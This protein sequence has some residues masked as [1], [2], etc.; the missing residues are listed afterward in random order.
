MT[1][2]YPSHYDR[3]SSR[4]GD[5]ESAAPT[6]PEPSSSEQDA[7]PG[8]PIAPTP[9]SVWITDGLLPIC[10]RS[11]H[12]P[13]FG[14]PPCAWRWTAS[15]WEA[16]ITG[17]SRPGDRVRVSDAGDGTVVDVAL[18]QGRQI[19][20]PDHHRLPRTSI[21]R[22]LLGT[23]SRSTS[24][25]SLVADPWVP[26]PS[27]DLDDLLII[28]PPCPGDPTHSLS[29]I[30]TDGDTETPGDVPAPSPTEETP[31]VTRPETE[32]DAVLAFQMQA[33]TRGVD[34]VGPGGV[35][36]VLTRITP[37]LDGAVDRIGPLIA[38]AQEVGL[39]YLQHNPIVH[40]TVTAGRINPH[41]GPDDPAWHLPPSEDGSV[42][43]RWAPHESAA[44][45]EDASA[46]SGD[47]A[48]HMPVH[49]DLIVFI[50]PTGSDAQPGGPQ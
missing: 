6:A 17:Y 19:T 15:L 14:E 33:V 42:P 11:G 25:A 1:S 13:A 40:A 32:M 38:H 49:S 43:W 4:P 12:C 23:F 2:T 50:K 29:S 39:R 41:F 27:G 7:R 3:H 31:E 46:H 47:P 24:G 44:T 45:G 34:L 16:I 30:D 35:V 20:A 8:W 21:Q 37:H 26:H 5:A 10:R 9:I 28:S 18:A 22:V 36:A 48:L